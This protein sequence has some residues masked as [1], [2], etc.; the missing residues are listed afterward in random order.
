MLDLYKVGDL[1]YI[2]EEDNL[3]I[4]SQINVIKYLLKRDFYQPK[5]ISVIH[6][7]LEDFIK[8]AFTYLRTV[9][10]KENSQSSKKRAQGPNAEKEFE[11]ESCMI[12]IIRTLETLYDIELYEQTQLIEDFFKNKNSQDLFSL[13]IDEI[14]ENAETTDEI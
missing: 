6:T 4:L 5:E 9:E 11:V 13:T 1:I 14:L 8:I 2:E 10:K 3:L 7:V 12:W